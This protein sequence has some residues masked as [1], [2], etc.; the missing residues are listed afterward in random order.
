LR[1]I[2]ELAQMHLGGLVRAVLRPHHRVHREL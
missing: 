2:V 1:E